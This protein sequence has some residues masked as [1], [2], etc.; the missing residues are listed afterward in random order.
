MPL[1]G[2]ESGIT[3]KDYQISTPTFQLTSIE[4]PDFSPFLVH[5]TGRNELISILK[6]DNAP[7]G[8]IIKE[9]SGYL[10]SVI[11]TFD[12]NHKYYNSPVVCFTESPL[13][14]IDFFRYRS[15]RRWQLDQQFG[16]GFA[17]HNL[18]KEN[19]VRPV[20]YLDSETNSA[21]LRLCNK[22]E[23][24]DLKIT[25][26]EHKTVDFS[27]SLAKIK[28]LLFPLLEDKSSQGFMWER[29][30]RYS[31]PEGMIFPHSAI[32]VICCPRNERQ[33]IEEILKDYLQN[34]QIVESWKEYDDVVEFLKRRRPE[35]LD[36]DGIQK[37]G[38][39]AILQKLK[40]NNEQTFNTLEAYYSVFKE[41]VTQLEGRSITDTLNDIA[42]TS[43]ILN[44]RITKLELEE[45]KRIELEKVKNTGNK[46]LQK[47]G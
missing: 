34:I 16:I 26:K 10:K 17:K 44:E 23:S 33:E 12:G 20:V 37:I 24:G 29:E 1:Q 38:D 32:K 22:I 13:F 4:K 14:A 3:W 18:I 9:E 7:N 11:P 31:S 42:K 36:L 45:E 5:M 35:I 46:V 40:I 41:T 30:W 39:L 15:F 6:G 27:Q 8:V 2:P 25:D 28:P 21:L 47:G 19:D 43:R